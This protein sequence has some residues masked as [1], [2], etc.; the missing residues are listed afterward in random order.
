MTDLE[1]VG[2]VDR[3]LAAK[4]P[5]R[6]AGMFDAIAARYDLLNRVLSVGLDR[7]WRTRAVEALELTGTETVLDLCTG[8]ADLAIAAVS[9]GERGARR[10]VGV[11]FALEMLRVGRG[12]LERRNLPVSLIRGDAVTLP[13]S[14][15]SVGAVTIGF[16]IRN[17]VSLDRAFAEILRVLRPGG[18]LAVLEFGLPR[19]PGLRTA[20][21]WYFSR[22]LPAVGALVSS[23]GQAY[24]YLPASV[25][26]FP[27]GLEFSTRLEAAGFTDVE[28]SRLAFGIVYLYVARRPGVRS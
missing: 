10:A 2:V 25:G 15:E 16:G 3:E 20:Y 26:T 1:S 7:R 28:Q 21:L 18:R 9:A 14:S 5:H 4:E 27:A 17:V 12:K 22:V 6:I 19:T 23:H 8:T 13:V 24:S 11:D